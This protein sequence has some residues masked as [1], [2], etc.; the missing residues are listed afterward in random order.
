MSDVHIRLMGDF[1][2]TIWDYI[3][4]MQNTFS[5]QLQAHSP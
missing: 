2:K 5:V 1:P 3:H 4:E